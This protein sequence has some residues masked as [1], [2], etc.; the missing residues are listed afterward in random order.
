MAICLFFII[1]LIG[2][3]APPSL[4]YYTLT[5]FLE[6]EES[7]AFNYLIRVITPIIYLL[8]ISAIFYYVKW[9][10]LVERIYLVSIYYVLFRALLN[11]SINR[12]PLINWKK[13]LFY[14][15]SI[16]I[17][18]FWTYKNIIEPKNN[19]LPDFS[20]MSN[21]IWLI[22]LIFMYTLLNSIS[23]SKAT[24]KK[25][26]E[27]YIDSR[28]KYFRKKYD[29]EITSFFKRRRLVQLVYAILIF[30]D[31]NRP[32]LF[33][34]IENINFAI[35][36]K[37]HTLGVMQFMSKQ[38]INDDE[39]LKLGLKKILVDYF[40]M[41]NEYV[42][43]TSDYYSE[44]KNR[45]YEFKLIMKYNNSTEYSGQILEL[46]EYIDTKYYKNKTVP[47]FGFN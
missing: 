40:E 4:K 44:N 38:Y 3:N 42:Y 16:V 30:E 1:N 37:P 45:H 26:K 32:K 43:D 2:Q 6:A 23:F 9:D 46:T 19:L 39:S 22:V 35:T 10:F 5:P 47:L 8:I 34:I 20:A 14:S 7:P 29:I 33:R 21:E 15:L 17:I 13:F 25:R 31:F 28:F 27:N 41:W 11:I 36:K 18:S 24:S 12:F